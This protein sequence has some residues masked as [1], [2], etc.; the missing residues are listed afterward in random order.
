[1]TEN[2]EGMPDKAFVLSLLTS[3]SSVAGQEEVF[4]THIAGVN[5]GVYELE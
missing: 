3:A 4:S 1:M 5:L 2:W